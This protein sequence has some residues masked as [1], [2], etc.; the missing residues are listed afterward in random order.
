MKYLNQNLEEELQIKKAHYNWKIIRKR[1][2][3]VQ[4]M[5]YTP[6]DEIKD[7]YRKK[8]IGRIEINPEDKQPSKFIIHPNNYWKM[9]WGNFL[10]VMTIWYVFLLP[11][12]VSSGST[13]SKEKL[14][15]LLV[16]DA[17]FMA[18]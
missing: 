16:F 15:S 1:I 13:L 2:K 9:Q 11:L 10:T 12:S 8:N 3:V 14:G 18:D 17:I 6:E 4:M 5:L 7:M